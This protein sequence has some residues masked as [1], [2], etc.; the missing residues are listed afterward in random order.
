MRD[1]VVIGGGLSGL[2]AG[3]E[4]EKRGARYTV[5]EVKA[6][7]GGAIHTLPAAGFLMDGAAFAFRRL[8]DEALLQE[9]G[10]RRQQV[11]IADGIA[12]FAHGTKTLLDALASRLQGGRL[13]RMAVSSIGVWRG[14][15]S[16]CLE[17]GMVLDAGAIIIAAPARYAARMLYNLAPAA[18]EC[19]SRFRYENILRLSLG[20]KKCELPADIATPADAAC[21]FIFAADAPA[22]LPSADYRLLQVGLRAADGASPQAMLAAARKRFG[23]SRPPA[24]WRSHQWAE[25]DLLCPQDS[26]H[27][28]AMRRIRAQLPAGISLIGSDYL[29]PA[30]Q[31]AGIARLQERLDAG[32][33]AAHD[34]IAFFQR[35]RR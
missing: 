25:A 7:F 12:V 18:A 27:A 4:L 9:L 33:A 16:I 11:E 20:Y 22:R 29:P 2:A 17:N 30:P 28:A 23:M 31:E 24:A 32:R 8:S 14:R 19:L 10:L 1:V 5:I 3:Y 26:K 34:A 35:R 15:F 6:R 13:L 21:R